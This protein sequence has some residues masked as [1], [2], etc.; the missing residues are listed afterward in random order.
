MRQELENRIIRELTELYETGNIKS[1]DKLSK[2]ISD[3]IGSPFQLSG[4]KY[5]HY[6][7][8]LV[9]KQTVFCHL[10]PGEEITEKKAQQFKRKHIDACSNKDEFIANY[11]KQAVEYAEKR[12]KLG[13]E[14][15]NFD[16]K[17]ALFLSGFPN[18]GID[19]ASEGVVDFK[20]N[21]DKQSMDCYNVL[22]QKT[23]F[24][25]LPYYSRKFKGIFGSLKQ[26]E[27]L[28]AVIKPYLEELLDA[29]I[30]HPR[31]YVLFGSAQ[32]VNLFRALDKTQ[33]LVLSRSGEV[34]FDIG[35]RFKA[36]FE[37]FH[38]KWKGVE[39][40]AGIAHTFPSQALPN[41]YAAMKKYGE[42]CYQEY[43]K[44]ENSIN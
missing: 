13:R 24:E 41:A 35:I 19:F 40:C 30:S 27:A 28:M 22:M 16:F 25:V 1:V 32:Y 36:R 15:D 7:A 42:L 2:E 44:F 26:S 17:Q 38:L 18:N 10:N 9:D 37:M 29:V 43:A 20:N 34:K 14:V 4:K 5:P 39:F 12:F 8:I 31:K 33:Q 6:N 3:I 11:Y 21:K 23:Q